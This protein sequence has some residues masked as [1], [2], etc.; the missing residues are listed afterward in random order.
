MSHN[1]GSRSFSCFVFRNRA[2]LER[3]DSR[4]SFTCAGGEIEVFVAPAVWCHADPVVKQQS[5]SVLFE[6]EFLADKVMSTVRVAHVAGDQKCTMQ[7]R[8][9]E[10]VRVVQKVSY[11]EAVK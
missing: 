7:E 1:L 9:V 4:G 3:S 2:P 6:S 11:A 10:V 5:L 8:Q